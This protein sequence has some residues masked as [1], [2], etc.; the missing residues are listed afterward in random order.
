[1]EESEKQVNVS[2]VPL[3]ARLGADTGFSIVRNNL[4]NERGYTKFDGEQFKCS[5]GWRSQF[6]GD[7]IAGYKAKWH[8]APNV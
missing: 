7:F 5:C 2:R 4:M 8:Q 1:M 3:N 6:S